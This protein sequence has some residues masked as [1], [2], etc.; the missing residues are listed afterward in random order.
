ME[1]QAA[2]GSPSS[3][4]VQRATASQRR[5][6]SGSPNTFSAQPSFGNATPVQLTVRSA[7]CPRMIS[8]SSFIW[9]RPTR[10]P[11]RSAISSGSGSPVVAIRA[12]PDAARQSVFSQSGV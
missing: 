1:R 10:S 4:L 8:V 9:A 5:S 11:S 7:I 3:S 6:T 12:F 2:T